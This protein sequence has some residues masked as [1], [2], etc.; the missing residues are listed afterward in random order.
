MH[1]VQRITVA[2][3]LS[4][5]LLGASLASASA[6]TERGERGQDLKHAVFVQSNAPGGNQILTYRR[7][8]NG[9]LQ[10]AGSF[11]TGGR[12]GRVEGAQVDP[13]ASQ[14]SLILDRDHD[15]LIGVNAGSNSVYAFEL[16]G[17]TLGRRQVVSSCGE[18][19]VSLAVHDNLLYVLN[20]G[21]A[22]SVVGYHIAGKRLLPIANSARSVGLTPA[23][24]PM[25]FLNT[26]GQVGFTPDGDHL[27]V[28]T[29]ANGSHIDVF[30][31]AR[32][33][34]LTVA[35]V[36]N[37][38]ATPVPFAFT[39]DS[40]GRLVVGEAGTSSVSTYVVGQDGVLEHIASEPDA[41]QALCWIL[42]IGDEY[43]VSNTGSGTVSGF[44][45]DRRG[46]PSVASTTS[47]G[48]GPIDLAT[49]RGG[50][51]LYVQLG[52]AGQIAAFK[53]ERNGNLVAI[54]TVPSST[55]QEGIVAV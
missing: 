29:K 17:G 1:Q 37:P 44:R 10:L 41:Q 11:D 7:A 43:F 16:D 5:A 40:R 38:S 53:L 30:G 3:L 34:R 51:F 54:G 46:D 19:P 8:D 15:L 45:V 18:F 22:G 31:V 21:G 52:G 2:L 20:A 4:F 9:T 25:A 33:G 39:F 24:G 23:T 47:V 49:P 32:D 50:A 42:R 28:T 55:D 12:G 35:P 6:Q 26:P 48:A 13:L 36:V 27:I 14:G